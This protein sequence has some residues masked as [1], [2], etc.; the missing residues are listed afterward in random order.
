MSKVTLETIKKLVDDLPSNTNGRIYTEAIKK[1]VVKFHYSSGMTVAKISQATGLSHKIIGTWKRYL[2][3]DQTAFIHGT[4]MRADVRTKALAVREILI[5]GN[6]ID[7]TANKYNIS[8]QT[9]N[10]WVLKYKD[11][12]ED[13]LDAP[14]GIP[15][16]VK[17]NKMVYGKT[18]IDKIRA[19]LTA[20]AEQLMSLIDTMHMTGEQA[21]A[22]KKCADE[23]IKKEA[24]LA[25]AAD[26]LAKQGIELKL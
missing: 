18:N 26:L 7:I 15:Y 6:G 16:I 13:L 10:T 14:D 8:V 20:Q 21:E 12:Y 1:T 3:T 2:G 4:K 17:Q 23:T 5:L 19:L 25:E 22:M 11:N 9:L 24:S